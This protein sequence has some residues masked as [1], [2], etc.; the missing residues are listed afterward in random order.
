MSQGKYAT[1]ILAKAGM[2]NCKPCASPISVKTAINSSDSLPFSQPALY[3]SIVGA[4]QYLTITRPDLAFAVN[5][6]CQH[7]SAPTVAHFTVVKRLLR[8]VKDS[9]DHGLF[10][11]PGS[12]TLQA[13]SD[14]D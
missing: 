1:D 11:S 12:F 6:A 14:S 9:L 10:F 8:Y 13:F 5:Q 2:L 4:L 7:V 3:G